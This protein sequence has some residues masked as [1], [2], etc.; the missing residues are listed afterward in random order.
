MFY[1]YVSREIPSAH[2][3]AYTLI[4]VAQLPEEVN[5][6]VHFESRQGSVNSKLLFWVKA[7]N[8]IH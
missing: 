1:Y 7:T 6:E 2:Y 5:A 8:I 4:D 3:F